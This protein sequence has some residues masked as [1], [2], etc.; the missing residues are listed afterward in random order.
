[1]L[2]YS[3]SWACHDKNPRFPRNDSSLVTSSRKEEISIASRFLRNRRHS[4]AVVEKVFFL[5]VR[6]V[7]CYWINPRPALDAFYRAT[8]WPTLIEMSLE[9]GCARVVVEST[10]LIFVP[11]SLPLPQDGSFVIVSF[12]FLFFSVSRTSITNH[13]PIISQGQLEISKR[14]RKRKESIHFSLF[15]IRFQF[16]ILFEISI[17]LPTYSFTIFNQECNP[18]LITVSTRQKGWWRTRRVTTGWIGLRAS[19]SVVDR[20]IGGV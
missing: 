13:L 3:L 2:L 11:F 1:M 18:N 19:I 8:R 4:S 16:L 9:N 6:P 10:C 5:E 14:R 15:E 17:F 7:F 20:R 12:S